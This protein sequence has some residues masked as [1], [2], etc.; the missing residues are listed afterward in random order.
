MTRAGIK[1]YAG[2][3]I[4]DGITFEELNKMLFELLREM[5]IGQLWGKR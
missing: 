5:T 3:V 4:C 2:A 1:E